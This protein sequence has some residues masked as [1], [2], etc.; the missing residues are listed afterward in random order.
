MCYILSDTRSWLSYYFLSIK[1]NAC[2]VA[3]EMPLREK[4]VR[5]SSLRPNFCL[6]YASLSD[7]IAYSFLK[8][9]KYTLLPLNPNLCVFEIVFSS[10]ATDKMTNTKEF[11]DFPAL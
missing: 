10:L 11:F 4:G 3:L 8:E 7:S 5:R 2:W 6:Q 1:A 9:P